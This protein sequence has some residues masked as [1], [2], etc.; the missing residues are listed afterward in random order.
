MD[1]HTVTPAT[2]I[3]RIPVFHRIA[4]HALRA[5]LGGCSTL[6]TGPDVCHRTCPQSTG[7]R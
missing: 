7:E 4:A 5:Y 6:K 1:M 2:A 3:S